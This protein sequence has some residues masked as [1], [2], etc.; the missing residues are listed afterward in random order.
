MISKKFVGYWIRKL[1]SWVKEK[2]VDLKK[3]CGFKKNY[4]LRKSLCSRENL[5]ARRKIKRVEVYGCKGKFC[6]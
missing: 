2:F 4:G 1:G 3:I 5:R 6:E